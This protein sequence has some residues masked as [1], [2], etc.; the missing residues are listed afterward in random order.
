[1]TD[2]PGSIDERALAGVVLAR[3]GLAAARLAYLPAG[4]GDHH[5]SLT[6][7]AGGEWFLTV[8][9]LDGGWRG[10]GPEAAYA[11]LRAVMDTV[12]ALGRA[13][14]DFAVLSAALENIGTLTQ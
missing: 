13:G 2:R 1:M 5:W 8:T 3:W 7:P 10:T 12:I 4:F 9:G 6:D 14:L 11:D